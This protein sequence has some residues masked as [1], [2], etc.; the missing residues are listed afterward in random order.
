MGKRLNLTALG[1]LLYFI[2]I[3]IKKIKISNVYND[4]C[5]A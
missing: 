2:N 1:G 4:C 5:L 3:T